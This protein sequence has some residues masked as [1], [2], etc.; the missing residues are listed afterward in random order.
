MAKTISFEEAM[1]RL[2]D[3]ARG[4]E[5][6][7]MSLDDS[8][9][10]YEEAIKLIKICNDKLECA[11]SKVRILTEMKDGTVTDGDFMGDNED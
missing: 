4:L 6:G 7:T 11:E 1:A 2:E 9:K 5:S 10:S 8:I 3:I